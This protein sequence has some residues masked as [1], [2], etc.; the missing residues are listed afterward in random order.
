MLRYAD[1]R[2]PETASDPVTLFRGY[3]YAHEDHDLAELCA[4]AGLPWSL[5]FELA[6]SAAIKG[7]GVNRFVVKANVPREYVVFYGRAKA[8]TFSSRACRTMSK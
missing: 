1:S 3:S 6:A 2:L 5:S 7:C 8:K 4:Q